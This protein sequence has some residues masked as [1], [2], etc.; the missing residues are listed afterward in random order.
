MTDHEYRT[1]CFAAYCWP[2]RRE[3]APVSKVSWARRFRQVTGVS[4]A[5]YV[6]P[7]R[8]EA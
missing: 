4:L 7:Y 5:E 3:I 8:R 1:Y 6:K 2:R